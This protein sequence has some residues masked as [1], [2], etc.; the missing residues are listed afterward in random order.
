MS[1]HQFPPSVDDW[2]VRDHLA[3]AVRFTIRQNTTPTAR[4]HLNVEMLADRI[5]EHLMISGFDIRKKEMPTMPAFG[6]SA[7]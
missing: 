3:S 4:K 7:R 5:V 6:P 1:E 2:T